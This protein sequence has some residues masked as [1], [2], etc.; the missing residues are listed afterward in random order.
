[1][2]PVIGDF[3]LPKQRPN[4]LMLNGPN[5]NMLGVREPDVYGFKNLKAIALEC[6]EYASEL[7]FSLDFRQSNLEGELVTM[8]QEAR[9]TAAGVIINGGAYS[10]TSIA[11]LDALKILEI[12]VIEVHISNVFKRESFRHHSYISE[13]AQGVIC[14]FG[15]HGYILALDAM[16]A[17]LEE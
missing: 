7:G 16:R 3:R 10:H 9:G 1:V 14:G 8:I 5:L 13:V 11:L 4:I 17:L 2:I 6:G 15:G 12:P